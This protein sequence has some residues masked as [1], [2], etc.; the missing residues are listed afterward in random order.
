M[1]ITEKF[2]SLPVPSGTP[3]FLDQIQKSQRF[4]IPGDAAP[5][6]FTVTK[7]DD[8]GC[9]CEVGI[10]EGLGPDLAV[11]SLFEFKNRGRARND[12]FNAVFIV[13]TGIGAEIGGHA[14]DATPVVRMLAGICDKLITHPNAVNASDLN[15]MTENT[16]YVEGSVLTRFL[17]GTVGLG[18]VRSNR[19][20][21][22]IDDHGDE[23]FVHAAVNAVSAA[24]ASF[25]LNCPKVIKME[26][27]VRMSAAYAGSGRAAGKVENFAALCDVLEKERGNYDAVAIASVIDVPAQYHEDYFCSGGQ[28]V[29]P[30]GG[31]EA[32]LTHAISSLFNVPSAH[33]PML[34]NR[35]IAYADTGIVEPRLAAEAVSMAF[36]HCILKGLHRSPEIVT[37]PLDIADGATLSAKDVSCLILPKG[38]LGLPTLAALRQGIPVIAVRENTNL[39]QNDLSVLP[40][41]KG[42]YFEVDNYFE[43]AGIMAAMRAGIDPAAVQRPLAPTVV[44]H[45]SSVDDSMG[46]KHRAVD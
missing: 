36:L 42:Q 13:P 22:I 18:K 28:M 20:L 29:N 12:S 4:R 1:K 19:V 6:R 37:D 9:E 43:A 5:I 44:D 34:E 27:P 32:L 45:I 30:W 10:L 7:S 11:G 21:T 40:W 14:G 46:E 17:M 26:H 33:S 3:N 8:D 39:M 2:L 16:V 24:R 35:E 15:E 38:C 41:P 31:V 25:G 23:L